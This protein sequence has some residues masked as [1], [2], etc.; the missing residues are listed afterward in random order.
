MGRLA[1]HYT[2]TTAQARKSLTRSWRKVRGKR[3][4]ALRA[5]LEQLSHTACEAHR[6][7]PAQP[8]RA[9]EAAITVPTLEHAPEPPARPIH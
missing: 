2:G 5:Q 3:W 7:A 9:D 6:G 8:A 4:R 1:E